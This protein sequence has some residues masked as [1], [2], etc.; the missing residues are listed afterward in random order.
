MAN[1]KQQN[2]QV[3][4]NKLITGMI[5]NLSTNAK[6]SQ[7]FYDTNDQPSEI[8]NQVFSNGLIGFRNRSYFESL[9]IDT[10][11]QL[12]FYQGMIKQ[13]GTLGS[14]KALQGAKFNNLDT[15]LQLFE[16]WAI[17]VGEYGALDTNQFIE[18]ALQDSKFDNNPSVFKLSDLSQE[19]DPDL[20]VFTNQDVYKINGTFTA[21][22]YSTV[23]DSVTYSIRSLPVAGYVNLEDVDFTIFD[24]RNFSGYGDLVPQ[25]NDGSFIWVAKDF[26]RSWNIYRATSVPGAA[27]LMRY[28]V[29]NQVEILMNGFH[30]LSA[31]D[32]IVLKNFN[33]LFNDIYQIQAVKDLT[34]FI[35]TI[36]DPVKLEEIKKQEVVLGSGIIYFLKSSRL[37]KPTDIIKNI[38][39]DGWL[40]NDKVWVD[41]L[42]S[43][44]DWGVYEKTDPWIFQSDISLNESQYIGQDHFGESISI[45]PGGLYMYGGAPDASSGKV[46]FYAR[47]TLNNF[48]F[49]SLVSANNANLVSY[50]Q[51][52]A[53]AVTRDFQYYLAVGAPSS[54]SNRGYVYIYQN[55][56]LIQILSKTSGTANDKFGSSLTFSDDGRYLYVGSAGANEVFCYALDGRTEVIDEII[57]DG[58]TTTFTLS[59]SVINADDVLAFSNVLDTQFLPEIDYTVSGTNITFSFIIDIGV[60]VNVNRYSNYFRILDTLPLLSESNAGDNFGSVV[61]CSK[62]GSII[63]VGANDYQY[64]GIAKAG[65]VFVYHKTQTEFT[66]DGIS[67]VFNCPDVFNNKIYVFLGDTLLI[68]GI[69]YYISG[70][71]SISFPTGPGFIPPP[72]G[73]ILRIETNQFK[74]DQTINFHGEVTSG[75][76]FG[77]KISMCGSGCNLVISSPQYKETNYNFGITSIYF[78]IGRNY[79]EIIGTVVNPVVNPG[80]SII[81]NNRQVVFTGSTLSSVIIDINNMIIPGVVASNFN[82]KLKI[83]SDVTVAA[84]KLGIFTG[85]SGTPLADLGIEIFKEVQKIKHPE[86]TGETFGTS[87]KIEENGNVLFVGSD[88]ADLILQLLIDGNKPISTTFDSS[89]TR[90][91]EYVKDTGAVY[92]YNR[93]PNPFENADNLPVFAFSQKIFSPALDT[94]YNF[95]YDIDVRNDYLVI[96]VPNSSTNTSTEGGKVSYFYN[97][98]TKSGWALI[99]NKTVRV[100]NTSINGVFLYNQKS[101]QI[102]SFLDNYD[103]AKGKI[104]GIADQEI[105]YKEEFDPA[106]Y[107][108]SIL[109]Q[110]KRNNSFYWSNNQVGRI[111]WDLSLLRYIDYEQGSFQYRLKNWG[112]LFPESQIILYEWVESD[113]LPSQYVQTGGDGVPKYSD[114]SAYS[115]VV[116]EDSVTGIK[117]QKYYY[118]VSSKDNVDSLIAKRSLSLKNIESILRDPKNQNIP[119]VALLA[120]DTTALYNISDLLSGSDAIIHINLNQKDKENIIHNEW[121]LIKEGL[122]S[123]VL[124]TRIISKLKDSLSGFDE[125]GRTVP[126]ASLSAND[127]FGIL[128]TP[129]QTLFVDRFNALKVFIQTV[130][131]ILLNY[132]IFLTT[133]PS[134]LYLEDPIPITGFDSTTQTVSDLD[135]LDVEGFVNEYKI[136]V[137]NDSNYNGLWSIYSFNSTT[138]EF[139]LFRI[140]SYRTEFNWEYLDWYSDSFIEGKEINFVID[141]YPYVQTLDLAPGNYIK[142]NNN[143]N[144]KW[145]IYE[146]LEDFS[147][148]LIAVE[149]AT[150][151][152]KDAI[153]DSTISSGFDSQTFDNTFLDSQPIIEFKNI[154]DSLYEQILTKNLS[155]EFNKLFFTM[156]NFIMTEQRQPDWIFKT[157]FVDVLHNLRTLQQF[158]NFVRDNQSFYQDY[159]QEVKPYRTQIKEYIPKYSALLD[160]IGDWSD[161]DLPSKYD[162]RF[163]TF[164]SPDL[165]NEFDSDLLSSPLYSEWTNNYKYQISD[166]IIGN[167]GFNYT[168]PPNVEITGGGG[169][170]ANAICTINA[171]GNITGVTIINPGYGFTSIPNVYI[172]GDGVGATAYPLFKNAFYSPQP[173]SSYNLV[174]NIST[175]IK[176]DRFSFNSNILS[177]VYDSANIQVQPTIISGNA[178]TGNIWISS[179][180]IISYNNEAFL[181]NQQWGTAMPFDYTIVTKL[182]SSN[183][184]LNA[185]DRITS[186]Y[187]PTVGQPAKD[188]SQLINGIEYPGIKVV[189]PEFTANSFNITSN[190]ISFNYNGLTINSGNVDLVD[191]RNLGFEVDQSIK[192][193]ANVPFDFH[194]NGYFTIV[195]VNRDS[196]TLTGQPVETTHKLILSTSVTANVGDYITQGNNLANAYVLQSVVNSAELAIIYSVPSFNYSGNVI[197]IN[198]IISSAYPLEVTTGGNVEAT[199]NYLDLTGILD[200][201]IYSTYLDTELGTRPEDINI[202]GGA[203]VDT[204]N[205]HS[206]EEL[207]PGRIFDT[208][209]MRVF[210]NNSSNTQSYGFRIFHPMNRNPEFTRISAGNT[211]NNST[212]INLE[213][214]QVIYVGDISRLAEPNIEKGI[215]GVVYIN[216][217]RINYWQR[218]TQEKLNAAPVWT[219]NTNFAINSIIYIDQGRVWG[220]VQ[221][222][223]TGVYFQI[224]SYSTGY[225]ATPL[226]QGLSIGNVYS[227]SGNLVGGINNINDVTVTVETD[228]LDIFYTANGITPTVQTYYKVLGNVYANAN[229]YVNRESISGVLPNQIA[230]LRRGVDGTGAANVIPINSRISDGSLNQKIL[231]SDYKI[232]NVYTIA[233]LKVTSNVTYRLTLSGN[234][235]ANIGSYITQ[236]VGNTGNVRILSNVNNS[237]IVAVDIIGGNLKL[238]SNIGTRINLATT[239]SYITTTAN[240][241]T[242]TP[243]GMINSNGNVVTAT[244]PSNLLY[245]SSLFIDYGTGVGL[246][247]S[248]N[249]GAE[250]IREEPSYTP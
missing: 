177:W 84:N 21:N 98:N 17:R 73:K 101:R 58:A 49:S 109:S 11:T 104:L 142:V 89:G 216:G 250:F 135:Y 117:T 62:D 156:I 149:A 32:I 92:I 160:A 116:I 95:G 63:A 153:Y 60:K 169:S 12:K 199:I 197:S 121:V 87:V 108:R 51:T 168:L 138:K 79:G 93:M 81:I 170:S 124:P 110:T 66:T 174:R 23:T 126:D 16:N 50:G 107:N 144:N 44:G 184:L 193:L 224:L 64:Q 222:N 33:D 24:I 208:L 28:I 48:E 159:I 90:F 20:T 233:N 54:A 212:N 234:I 86:F 152:I 38:P 113:F 148:D 155:T 18:F 186:Y 201:N 15:E 189:G 151:K 27:F 13:K 218:I 26:N 71:N 19:V 31:D 106:S 14:I 173:N 69:D 41:T 204:Y 68:N 226:V 220:N 102:L 247:S 52:L 127:K 202:V 119:Y 243:L 187:Q 198:G 65:A 4:R 47:N 97:Q 191:F 192:I 61:T 129:L 45:T 230:Q 225:A 219:S 118:W 182:D 200:S 134:F 122:G 166:F 56:V 76:Q 248:T 59:S 205:S 240:I 188:L 6:Q 158:P 77:S 213:T 227:I 139:D 231:G 235:T 179:G 10:T 99:R 164:R 143:G 246:E 39:R 5:K 75:I 239:S 114:D 91:V 72:K 214:D 82:N 162:I 140:Q 221:S 228:G 80:E 161:F 171:N 2:R 245:Q 43:K 29:D 178:V 147:L 53:S 175:S 37:E 217:E 46:G 232:A 141:I 128:S 137:Q 209:E 34:S 244:L 3:N 210:T 238:A 123:E 180:N 223:V 130:N 145:A 194:N 237:N 35:V 181:L 249:Q 131:E 36:N 88:G 57:G 242:I 55:N 133:T 215:P 100:D 30:E 207:I 85:G 163:D 167:V 146:V 70:S 195:N 172:N 136:L 78:N 111:W 103:P 211:T 22:L 203:Y 229:A 74:L 83:T 196:M 25:I 8:T 1:N 42:N 236:F 190:V 183:V 120:P 154:F 115:S 185:A 40:P 165:A 105:D 150:L 157:S 96:G 132:P 112:S 7:Q 241:L 9:G 125:T 206:P 67:N 176:F 94:G